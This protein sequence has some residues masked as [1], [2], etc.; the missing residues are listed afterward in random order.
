MTPRAF[1]N[2]NP[3]Y[4]G[5]AITAGQPICRSSSPARG[6]AEPYTPQPAPLHVQRVD[7]TGGGVHGMCGYYAAHAIFMCDTRYRG[8]RGSLH[9]IYFLRIPPSQSL[10]LGAL[11]AEGV[12]GK[13]AE[14]VG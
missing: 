13:G 4:V 1:E 5:G 7:A 12:V 10:V 11:E 6:E 3:N 14:R 9:T 2:Y 8:T